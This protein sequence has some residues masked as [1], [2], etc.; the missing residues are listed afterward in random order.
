MAPKLKV[1]VG[2]PM[3][4][5]EHQY[6]SS[7]ALVDLFTAV[8]GVVGAGA[9]LLPDKREVA[10][11]MMAGAG[12]L[13]WR[14]VRAW[15]TPYVQLSSERLA[16]Y[17]GRCPKHCIE[18]AEVAS[19]SQGWNRTVFLMRDGMKTSVSHL[20]FR[21]SNDVRHFRQKLAERFFSIGTAY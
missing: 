5:T 16:V 3:D 15:R 9:A 13:A 10:V 11:A 19:V 1:I 21:S 8:V 4:A 17:E 20:G 12:Y 7:E 2:P 18:F 6:R 14:A